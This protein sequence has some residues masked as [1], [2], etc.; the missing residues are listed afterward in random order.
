MNKLLSI[1]KGIGLIEV[2][3]STVIVAIGLLSIAS[4]QGEFLSASGENKTKA[5]AQ[6]LAE[7]KIEE[8]KNIMVVS[9]FDDLDDSAATESIDGV[10]EEFSRSW[11]VTDN[12]TYK[13]IEVTVS[14]AGG[15]VALTNQVVFSSPA[16]SAGIA[17][18]GDEG[19][20]S[21]GQAP[22]PNQGASESI[23]EEVVDLS[24]STKYTPV[25]GDDGLY[26]DGT[27]QYRDDG[28]GNDQGSLVVTCGTLT[29]FD[30]DLSYPENY[31]SEGEL[32]A[33][34]VSYLYTERT[35]EDGVEVILLYTKDF[36]SEVTTSGGVTTTTY[37][38]KTTC[39]PQHRYFG[40]VII[41]IKGDIYTEFN[42]DDIKVDHN[43]ED[44][45]CAFY[46]GIGESEQPYACYVGGNCD[47]TNGDSSNATTCS[48]TSTVRNEVGAGGFSGNI[49]LLNVDDEGGGKENVCFQ[50]DLLGTSTD[51]FTA[52]KYKTT[53]SG[54][55]KEEGINESYNCQ[56][57]Y[58]VGRQANVGQLAAEC[59]AKVGT[60]NLNLPPQEVNRDIS[61]DN[62]VVT[63]VNNSYCSLSTPVL[64][65]LTI[66][67]LDEVSEGD[68]V[69]L[70][71]VKTASGTS[72]SYSGSGSVYTCAES[73]SG[74]SVKVFVGVSDKTGSCTISD[75]SDPTCDIE[76]FTP[77]IYT[78]TG[79]IS[80]NGGFIIGIT[81]DS[82]IGSPLCT[83]N[84]SFTC[85][86][87]TNESSVRIDASKNRSTDSCNK[88]GL[89]GTVT[90]FADICT[91]E[92]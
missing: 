90:S 78:L 26:T 76:L 29:Q 69:G 55:G 38:L 50:G 42:L 2:L 73:T 59:S 11:S 23:E 7:Q 77:P 60:L 65:A 56:D 4:M 41:P 81:A 16:A 70:S 61:G 66:T 74:T 8:V 24:D 18:Y 46:A 79:T 22:S 87:Q 51:F 43:K 49:G 48:S 62:I 80:V 84:T 21:F 85:T 5:E 31:D 19:T 13:E 39:T 37:S 32:L 45:F 91:L 35:T 30:I 40:G 47:V 63:T 14:W 92:L 68:G 44:M 54:N 15:S 6:V 58:I 3:I 34:P 86:I 89:D 67:V 36:T 9:G 83:E 28:T 71:V 1:E 72:C 52:R 64:Y 12:T 53:N 25:S 82:Y 10:N 88:N 33:S 75:L 57:F 20:G 27:N 17:K